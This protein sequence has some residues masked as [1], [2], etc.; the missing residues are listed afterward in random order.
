MERGGTMME[1]LFDSHFIGSLLQSTLRVT[2]PLLLVALGELYGERAGMINIGLDGI[3]TVGATV[4]FIVGYI[5]VNPVLGLVV[6]ALA[7]MLINMIYAYST[8]TLRSGQI[9]NGMAL[10]ILAPALS[11]FIF[12][13]YFGVTTKLI[14]GT[15]LKAIIVP[16]LSDIPVLGPALFNQN[17]I[18][19]LAFV[20]AILTAIFFNKTKP[21]LDY[22]AVG[23]FPK[24]AETLGI[25]VIRKKYIA[26]MIC[27]AFAGLGGAYLNT[28]YIGTYAEGVVAGRGFIALSA[29][30]F[31]GWR[32]RGLVLATLLF[33]FTDAIQLRFQTILP[34]IPYQILAMLPY[35]STI[36]ALFIMRNSGLAPRANGTPYS[37][38]GH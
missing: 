23:E 32:V 22:R 8:I 6:G 24:A 14:Q 31:G 2:T 11:I 9:I 13:Q 33:G 34:G 15:V 25:N 1:L 21:G 7:G 10:N 5:T 36:A 30:I 16:V 4:G 35:L 20:L 37:R 29:V 38:E 17:P 12:R 27:G 18:T 19:Y 26:C 28:C 3:M